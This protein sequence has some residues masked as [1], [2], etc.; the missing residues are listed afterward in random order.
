MCL[1]RMSLLS[2]LR[3]ELQASCKNQLFSRKTKL[4]CRTQPARTNRA[5]AD[6]LSERRRARRSHMGPAPRRFIASCYPVE[7]DGWVR[8]PSDLRVVRSLHCHALQ[9]A[10]VTNSVAPPPD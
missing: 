1:R 6:D 3:H 7:D 4:K 5:P 2:S 10:G 9:L 8:V